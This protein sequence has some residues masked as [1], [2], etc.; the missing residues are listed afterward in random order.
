MSTWRNSIR[1]SHKDQKSKDVK[2]ASRKMRIR[3][4]PNPEFRTNPDNVTVVALSRY[5]HSDSDIV[6]IEVYAEMNR[7][8][9]FENESRHHGFFTQFPGMAAFKKS[10]A[11][12]FSR[13]FVF[14]CVL[15][16]VFSCF[17]TFVLSCRTNTK[18]RNTKHETPSPFVSN[19]ESLSTTVQSE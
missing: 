4:S 14:S 1:Q 11:G 13:A 8:H 10:G 19:H 9:L 15:A 2:T 5:R 12:E 16:F 18:A 7:N 6:W 17:L 3:Q